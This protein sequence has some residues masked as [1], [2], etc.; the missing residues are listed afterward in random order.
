M[1][2][3][4]KQFNVFEEKFTHA[5]TQKIADRIRNGFP[6]LAN[7]TGE[8]FS[9]DIGS[10]INF[11][12]KWGLE[13]DDDIVRLVYLLLGYEKGN[14]SKPDP[15]VSKLMTWP[16]RTAEDKLEYL[17]NYLLNKHYATYSARASGSQG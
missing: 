5:Y 7:K 6:E 8:H 1:I 16:N 15:E 9:S 2:F 17:H 13:K 3:T 4:N 12:R 10:V 11:S 14:L